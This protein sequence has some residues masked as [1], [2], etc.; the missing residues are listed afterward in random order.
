M[1]GARLS[2][3]T[4]KS[5]LSCLDREILALALPATGSQLTL[6]IHTWVDTWWVGRLENEDAALAALAV[7]TFTIWIF[8]SIASILGVGLT[9]LIA[10][11]VGR[12]RIGAA[13]YIA[14]QG[15]LQAVALGVLTAV[16]GWTMA[17]VVFDLVS[18]DDAVRESG[19]E[20]VQIFWIGGF[21]ILIA[22]SCQATFRAHGDTRTPFVVGLL[23]IVLNAVLDPIFM[24]GFAFVPR[25]G[26][27]GVAL[28]TVTTTTT[29]ALVLLFLLRRR[30]LVSKTYPGDDE[31][32]LEEHTRIGRP[33][34]LGFDQTLFRRVTRIGL[35]V[36]QS[37]VLF[38][39][40]YLVVSRI[41]ADTGG[42]AAQ[43]ALG[44]GHRGEGIAFVLCAGYATAAA[45]LVGRRIGEGKV[46]GAELAAWRCVR[47][48]ALVCGLWGFAL[49]F[50]GELLATLFTDPGP[51]Q[52]ATVL[53]YSII[54]WCLVPQA[55]Q[56]VL[57]GAFGGAGLTI[58]PMVISMIFALARIPL[59]YCAAFEWN[60]GVAGIW[61]VIS[62]TS[63]LRGLA[64]GFWFRR[65]T[66]KTQSV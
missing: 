47:Q 15:I 12:R 49:V 13:R 55:I 56:I 64:I 54:A 34:W 21:G 17:P 65:G 36:A 51:T 57:E 50:A 22:R 53:Y 59:A 8:A 35:P 46:I 4:P 29:L 31:I 14:Y 42:T 26:V 18:T 52:D 48:C 37:G 9:A 7:S 62:L 3:Q 33:R 11:Y 63:I 39:L 19:T 27:P 66:W 23:G 16:I 28:A 6:L 5:R 60:L 30:R 43:A 58:P 41:A 32:R 25:L 45:S 38:S 24:F 61:W 2:E 20:Y 40:I 44:L 10:R 1:R